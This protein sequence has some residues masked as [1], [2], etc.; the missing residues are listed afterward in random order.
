MSNAF[1]RIIEKQASYNANA[2]M[3]VVRTP[4]QIEDP[5]KKK[6]SL[7]EHLE[8]TGVQCKVSLLHSSVF[9]AMMTQF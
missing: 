4:I 5:V 6:N 9:P 3:E 2:E 1:K 7:E 8:V